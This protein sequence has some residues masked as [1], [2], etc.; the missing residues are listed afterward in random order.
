MVSKKHNSIAP[1]TTV[2]YDDDGS[3]VI[4]KV[5][6]EVNVIEGTDVEKNSLLPPEGFIVGT[7]AGA[8]F[9]L[10][11]PSISRRHVELIPDREGVHVRDLGSTNGTI[12]GGNRIS[13]AFVPLGAT[14]S[15]GQTKIEVCKL[16]DRTPLPLSRRR[17]LGELIGSSPAMRRIYSL[18]EC[19][20]D[21]EVTVLLE[22]ETG[23]GKELAA[24]ALHSHSP[25][26]AGPF[27]IIDCGA[28]SPSLIESELFGHEK[29]SFTSADRER[30][31]AFELADGGSLFFDEIGELPL[32]L[33]PKLLRALESR[34]IQ[35][36]GGPKRFPVDV[37]FVAATN[38]DLAK[39]VKR[40]RFREDLYYRL[41][42]FKVVLPPL[43]DHPEDI[44][45]LIKHFLSGN[46][47]PEDI[48]SRMARLDW[49]GNVRE[50][51]NAIERAVVLARGEEKSEDVLD[52]DDIEREPSTV[53]ALRFDA[54]KPFK[55]IKAELIE[56]FEKVYI[57]KVLKRNN[58]NISAS[59][60]ESGIDRKHLERLIRK[61]E[62]SK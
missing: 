40:G 20:A 6:I 3:A 14:L 50:L 15:L 37:R 27:Q 61:H 19:A 56:S 53:S 44:P 58:G 12:V 1:E 38:R 9:R 36:I 11:D 25:R 43:R 29:G 18:L 55:E 30:A 62:I 10:T 24:R 13:E 35:R 26:A 2:I 8:G 34:E 16:V 47:L 49:P 45:L 7:H 31:G 46:E 28:V 41:N 21:A 60:R 39:E 32:S 52:D 23:T 17:R 51:R 54:T 22:G 4:E 48:T 57:G 33:Q 42:V 5:Q 59:A